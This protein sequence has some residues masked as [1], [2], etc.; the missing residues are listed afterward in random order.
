M[1]NTNVNPRKPLTSWDSSQ[2]KP[3]TDRQ[4]SPS[5]TTQSQPKIIT[6]R[7]STERSFVMPVENVPP[8]RQRTHFNASEMQKSFSSGSL[9]ASKAS[10][11]KV[12][13]RNPQRAMR[14]ASV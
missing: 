4:P 5:H 6:R 9:H 14:E 8:T 13:F 10:V 1:G 2:R 12:S 7:P 11:E 3:L